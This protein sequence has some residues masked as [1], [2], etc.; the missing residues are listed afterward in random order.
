MDRLGSLY[1]LAI[2]GVGGLFG[3]YGVYDN[4]RYGHYRAAGW[5][6]LVALV[7]VSPLILVVMAEIAQRR[8]AR[9]LEGN[10]ERLECEPVVYQG[11]TLTAESEVV[12]YY[13]AFSIVFASFKIPS[14]HYIVG[15]HWL[16][17]RQAVYSLLSFVL[18]WWAVPWG[19]VYTLQALHSNLCNL[20]R[21]WLIDVRTA[22]T[23]EA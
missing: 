2:P 6:A 1:A 4:L 19:P 10:I 5:A 12:I 7:L 16:W 11:V 17:P 15:H 8:F 18:G 20:D 21:R 9:W 22:A 13:L 14:R 23:W 3:L